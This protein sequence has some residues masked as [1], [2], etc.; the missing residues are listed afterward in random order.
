MDPPGVDE[1]Q[2]REGER[3]RGYGVW[4]GDMYG[5]GRELRGKRRGRGGVQG[6][7]T[8]GGEWR[9]CVGEG[10]YKRCEGKWGQ[11]VSGLLEWKGEGGGVYAGRV[12]WLTDYEHELLKA[13]NSHSTSRVDT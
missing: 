13:I 7:A 10:E 5:R 1:R 8:A 3:R 12:P 2:V 11:G 4:E 9:G 6:E